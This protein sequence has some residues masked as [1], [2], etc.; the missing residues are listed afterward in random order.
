[1]ASPSSLS[2]TKRSFT[3]SQFPQHSTL[4]ASV[5]PGASGSSSII[6][7]NRGYVSSQWS[8]VQTHSQLTIPG[9]LPDRRGYC[10]EKGRDVAMQNYGAEMRRVQNRLEL[11]Q[12]LNKFFRI[13]GEILV[14]VMSSSSEAASAA[15]YSASL[16]YGPRSLGTRSLRPQQTCRERVRL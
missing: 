4:S 7:R 12:H 16:E 5:S 13:L 9:V 15:I 8:R 2:K 6:S 1:M 10:E 14:K 11:V 3:F